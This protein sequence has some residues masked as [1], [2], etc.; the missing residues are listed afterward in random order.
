MLPVDSAHIGP[1]AEDIPMTR[2]LFVACATLIAAAASAAPSSETEQRIQRIQEGLVPQVLVKGETPALKSLAARMTELNVP[3]VS[4]AVIHH[5]RIEWARGFGVTSTGGAAVTEHSLFQAAS[6]S[7]PVFALGVLHQVDAGKLSLDADVNQ[8][9][10]GWKLPDNEFTRDQKV[11]LRRL[12]SHSAGLTVHGFPGYESGAK[13]PTTTQILDGVPPANTQP[14]R[15]DI[16]PGTRHRYSGGGYTVAQLALSDVTGVPLPKLLRD[17][18]LTP[19]GMSS[20]TFEQPLPAA[21]GAEV[22]LPHRGDG[23]PV[24]GGAHVYPEM[25]AAGLWTTPSDLARYALGVR[26]AL[27]GKSKVISAATARVMLTPVVGTHGIGPVVG[28]NSARKFF[29]HNGG[30][31]GYRCLLVSYEDGEGAVVMTNGDGGGQLTEEL[32]RTIARVYQWP[33][34]APPERAV[35]AVKPEMLDRL[36]G[37]YELDEKSVYVVRRN[38]PRLIG[39]II[40][41]TPSEALPSAENQLFSRDFD[42]VVTFEADSTGA[43]NAIRHR[44]YDRHR[45]GKR[46]DAARARQLMASVE[47]ADLRFKEQKPDARSEA[48]IRKLFAGLA[49]GNPDY[50]S[51]SPQLADLTRQ[52]IKGV[53]G[54]IAGMG[55]LKALGFLR[56]AENGADEYDADFANGGLRIQMGLDET[57]R[58]EIINLRPR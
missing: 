31:E 8:Y 36:I 26:E 53:Q 13:L 49:S 25:A 23:T 12:L 35:A 57:G 10:K 11:T 19:L 5:G 51:M 18:V 15:A 16:V 40:G 14:I 34:F 37:V 43:M 7:K 52:Q 38:G 46:V 58:A 48:A 32:M 28:G 39:N 2:L 9:L 45:T 41:H 47:R 55:E 30:N 1:D 22:A 3:G 24:K 33:D 20:S 29:T 4:I 42:V 6:I 56:V 27:T 44:M 54:F 21:R 50:D 17:T